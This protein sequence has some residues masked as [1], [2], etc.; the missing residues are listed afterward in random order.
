MLIVP[1]ILTVASQLNFL[2]KMVGFVKLGNIFFRDWW[3]EGSFK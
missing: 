2:R 3:R 1:N